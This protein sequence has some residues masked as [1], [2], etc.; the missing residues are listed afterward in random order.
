MH[1]TDT[2]AEEGSAAEAALASE[3]IQIYT[4]P[5]VTATGLT[6]HGGALSELSS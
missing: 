1:P 5:S 3:P 6:D 4:G 2:S